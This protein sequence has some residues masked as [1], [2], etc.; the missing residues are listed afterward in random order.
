MYNRERSDFNLEFSGE[1]T[2]KTSTHTAPTPRIKY[3]LQGPENTNKK[4]N[5]AVKNKQMA[6]SIEKLLK[7]KYKKNPV[8]GKHNI[9][10]ESTFKQIM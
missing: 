6:V 2:S 9:C 7:I 3:S 5:T 10:N 4:K 1:T 8:L